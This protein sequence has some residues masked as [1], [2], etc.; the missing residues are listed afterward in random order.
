MILHTDRVTLRP[1]RDD[2]ADAF[3]ALHA[4]PAVM[5]DMP[6]NSRDKSQAK[7]ER[8]RAAFDRLGFCRWAL[9]RR[10]GVFLGYVGLMPVPDDNPAAGGV[11]I[12]WRL[13]RA[14]WGQGYA[15]EGARAALKD[16]FDRSGLAEVLSY[17]AP[18]NL[19]SQA[20]MWRIGLE[21]DATRDFTL[22]TPDGPWT[23]LMW[24][25]RAAAW[26]GQSAS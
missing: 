17:T 2:D 21:R 14:A 19:R 7:L 15:S 26:R 8:Y 3:V 24:V 10:D 5:V 22:E 18:Q 25:A 11:E 20:V 4:D 13:V 9:E 12:G 16:G 1:W 6:V 23:G